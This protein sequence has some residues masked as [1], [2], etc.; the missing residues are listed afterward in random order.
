MSDS[1]KKL[2]APEAVVKNADK[3]LK[4]TSYDIRAYVGEPGNF[5]TE[6]A[7]LTPEAMETIGRILGCQEFVLKSGMRMSLK[8]GDTVVIGYDNGPTS[9]PLAE[10]MAKGL[11]SQG[12]NVYDIGTSSSGQVYQ[13]QNQLGAKA[14]VQ[15]TRSHVEVTTNGAKFG[16]STQGVHTY[17]LEQMNI[18]LKEGYPVR[19]LPAEKHGKVTDKIKEGRDVYFSKMKAVYGEYFS[20]RD[21]SKTAVNLF[22][23]TGLQYKELF[24]DILGK[25]T[26][27]LGDDIDVNSGHLLADPTR[28]EML[29]KVPGLQKALDAGKRVHSF[30]LDADRG[31]L[32][33]G[34]DALSVSGSG[35]YLGDNLAFILADHKLKLA[36]PAL[37]KALKEK[38]VNETNLKAVEK[39]AKTFYIDPRYTGAVKK[40]IESLGGT[41][42]FHPK[43]HS[44][45]KETITENMKLIAS[46]AGYG[47]IDE[48]VQATGYRDLQ[49][50]ASLHF[51]ST[52]TADGIPRDDAVENIFILEQVMDE[53][54]IDKLADYF[55]T[56][57]SRFAT[58]EI[59]TVAASNE[60]KEH[61]TAEAVAALRNLFSGRHGFDVTEFDGQIRVDFTEGFLMYGMSNTSPKLT[62]MAEGETVE[63]RNKALAF[64]L[65]LHNELKRKYDDKEPMD[66]SENDFF[67]KDGS[68]EMSA[69]DSVY[70]CDKRAQEF[71][72]HCG[73]DKEII[74]F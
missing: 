21:N 51:F 26:L 68:Y 8:V 41:T 53:L 35:H 46:L 2:D 55:K 27:I 37:R 44:L 71:M 4:P 59:R 67:T 34:S 52:D 10:A 23:G 7:V 65:A 20:K 49:I 22:G 40:Y 56:V 5:F 6:K 73:L 60:Q 43:G 32:T 16:I 1:F 18:F 66:L 70:L 61:I 64:V 9:K 48:F 25:D 50:E 69:P 42:V 29:A 63:M 14:H 45:W 24:L 17:L 28:K 36:L 58:K 13:N 54:G 39:I 15:I 62:F 30:D 19:N 12:V 31:S 47:S 33:E 11:N 57:P 38:G 72:D 3:L 74:G